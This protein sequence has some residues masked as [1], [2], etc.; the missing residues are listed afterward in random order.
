[1]MMITDCVFIVEILLNSYFMGTV[2]V[3]VV[4]VFKSSSTL[5]LYVTARLYGFLLVAHCI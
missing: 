1:M 5:Q 4:W 2:L 3:T